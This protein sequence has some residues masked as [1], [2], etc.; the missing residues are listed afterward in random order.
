MNDTPKS[1]PETITALA[2]I[3]LIFADNAR[4]SGDDFYSSEMR[5]VSKLLTAAVVEFEDS[6]PF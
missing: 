5:M 6:K 3:L 4:D 1:L 2:A